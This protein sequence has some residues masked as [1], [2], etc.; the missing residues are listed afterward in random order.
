MRAYVLG[1]LGALTVIALFLGAVYLFGLPTAFLPVPTPTLPAGGNG[2]PIGAPAG[3]DPR[4]VTP[5][6]RLDAP[7]PP[8]APQP[9]INPTLVQADRER[10]EREAAT[11][12]AQR[13]IQREESCRQ[14]ELLYAEAKQPRAWNRQQGPRL[15]ET[16]LLLLWEIDPNGYLNEF[17]R[18]V[19]R[20][21]QTHVY[22][23]Y[24][25]GR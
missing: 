4:R 8:S 25:Y 7:G 24:G 3:T 17:G 6:M 15:T 5:G 23:C 12:A 10:R 11:A 19:V 9:T 1:A 21:I 18:M 16:E 20:D 13:A 2:P 14:V 22:L